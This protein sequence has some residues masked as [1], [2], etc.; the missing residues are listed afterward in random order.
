ML[1][2][3]VV[4]AFLLRNTQTFFDEGS[5][6]NLASCVL[7]GFHLYRDVF[8]NHFPFPVYLSAALI[9]FTGKSLPLVRLAVLLM[10]A[11]MFFAVLRVTGLSFPV[12]FAAAVWAF[13]SPYYFGN[14][15]LYDNL[16][17]IGGFA[18]G[19][20]CFAVHARG[21]A[22]SRGMFVL[23]AVAGLVASMSNP[24][25]GLVTAIAIGS[26]FLAPQIPRM[27]VV[28][29][30]LT[31]ALPIATYFGYL[32]ASGGLGA[33]YS[34]TIVFNTVTYQ[35]Y[36]SLKILPT[37]GKQLL[38][39]NLFNPYWFS[40]WDP[41]RFNPVTFVP[42]FDH[43]VFSGL[44]YRVAAIGACLLFAARREYRTALFLYL[45]TATLPLRGDDLFH[46]AP[47]VFF[48]LFLVGILVEEAMSLARPWKI[49]LLACCVAP[50]LVLA[51]SGGRYVAQHALQSDF[52]RLLAE[53][54][55]IRQAAQNR[56]DVQLG[57][58][59]D[60]NYMYYLT[61][62]R[63]L[64]KFVDFYP[65]VAEIGKADVD[66]KLAS[67]SNVVLVMDITGNV[68]TYPNYVTLES[69]IA[70]AKEH[71]VKERFG[72]LTVYV[73][74]SIAARGNS[75]TEVEFGELGAPFAESK[76]EMT[77]AWSRD[78]YSPPAGVSPVQ[79]AVYGTFPRTGS[80]SGTGTL[81]WGPFRLDRHSDMG[82]PV[83][84]GL[85]DRN[86][87]LLVRDAESKK[88]LARMDHPPPVQG[89]WW[90]WHPKL[91]HESE[92]TV[93]VIA[94]DT[95]AEAGQWMALGWPHVLRQRKRGPAF[96]P[97]LYRDGEWRLASDIDN[98]KGPGTRV[99]HFGQAGDVPVT[100][101]WDGSGK[102]R[103]GVYRPASGEWLLDYNGSGALDAGDRTYRFGG[104]AGDVPVTGDW[105]GSGKT[106]IGIYR[107][108]T[109]E[110]LLDYNGD[111]VF[112]AAQD[113][114]YQ[115]GGA[116]GDR[117]VVGDWTGSGVSHIGIVRQDYR[118][119][120]DTNGNG[121]MDEGL[122]ATFYFGGIPGDVLLT[123]DWSGDGRTKPGIFRRDH[124]WLFDVDGNYRFDDAGTSRDVVFD[125]GGAGDK[126]VTG[127]W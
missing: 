81:R 40:S 13:I 35:K 115:F 57:H 71:L 70:Y 55:F 43:W 18:L 68:W 24:F 119:A 60:G 32:A 6:L 96:K 82:I 64:S 63:P 5:N 4:I 109:G 3:Y 75:G 47:F 125:F 39:F 10:D 9:F 38:L 52:D 66:A 120:L 107:P 113:R 58:Y 69:E 84:T 2:L 116:V 45:F 50:T 122:D 23:L 61:G 1:F 72:W 67:A 54:Q 28:K 37:L 101:D 95:G 121:Q 127:A 112:Q 123:G 102:T 114:K 17:M 90:G 11:G 99:Y 106:K 16:A 92:L 98:V 77:G 20:V 22:A 91:P 78:G 15:L 76:A 53:A 42:V 100:G 108:S 12:G 51:A 87:S 80:N 85:D 105:D 26:L 27:F 7:K 86:L 14:L 59:P 31:I 41:L 48:C 19:A 8:E 21:L 36:A 83:V 74:P 88:V 110:W 65:W 62:L 49:A 93:E 46:A 33:F 118:W 97:G 94:E 79:G 44:F 117:P 103:I 89:T 126:P 104:Q 30:G 29:L 124:Q 111:G 73:S 34:Y 56:S 25:F